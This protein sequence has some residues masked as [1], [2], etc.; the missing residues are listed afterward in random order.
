MAKIQLTPL[1]TLTL[2]TVGGNLPL[3]LAVGGTGPAGPQG[4]QGPTG[5]QG[6]QGAQGPAGSQGPAG[7]QGIQ[8][9][10]GPEGPEGPQGLQGI[11]GPEGPQ[12]P[13]GP[14]GADGLNAPLVLRAQKT[15]TFYVPSTTFVADPELTSASLDTNSHYDLWVEIFYYSDAAADSICRFDRAGLSDAELRINNAIGD[16]AVAVRTWGNFLSASGMGITSL[17]QM[18]FSG[19]VI[20]GAD[21]GQIMI[22]F[23]Q[24][25]SHATPNEIL[26]GSYLRLEKIE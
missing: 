3:Q 22:E 26:R 11:Q 9:I 17:R 18:T 8:G 10:Q 15:S 25:S 2:E 12:G 19:Q 21:P 24:S 6:V 20:T 16:M 5:P 13:T 7:P 1:Y 23:R 4:P 14:A